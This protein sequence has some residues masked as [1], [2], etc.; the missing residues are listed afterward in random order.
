MPAGGQR[1]RDH[2]AELRLVAERA[3]QQPGDDGPAVD[4]Q[5][6]GAEQRGGQEGVLPEAEIPEHD[7]KRQQHDQRG[8]AA[9][10][11]DAAGDEQVEKQRQ[12]LRT[13]RRRRDTAA[14]PAR[15]TA[16]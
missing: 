1:Q 11:E 4:Q 3:E 15:R 16:A 13:G 14:A 5:R 9:V 10:P 6:G 7:R 8:G 12:R 2:Q